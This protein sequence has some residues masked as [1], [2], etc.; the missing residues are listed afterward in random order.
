MKWA[1]AARS[2]AVA[3]IAVLFA[4][5]AVA[6]CSTGC[7]RYY[8]GDPSWGS[9]ATVPFTVSYGES[10]PY[11]LED[12]PWAQSFWRAACD[13]PG[14]V[15]T[16]EYTE[17]DTNGY[18]WIWDE[19]TWDSL[20]LWAYAPA[21]YDAGALTAVGVYPGTAVFREAQTYFNGWAQIAPGHVAGQWGRGEYSYST[22]DTKTWALHETG[23]WLGLQDLGS[24]IPGGTVWQDLYCYSCT[25]Y[26]EISLVWNGPAVA[27]GDGD[28]HGLCSLYGS[29]SAGDITSFAATP[30]DGRVR[31]EWTVSEGSGS[32]EFRIYASADGGPYVLIYEGEGESGELSFSTWDEEVVNG[33]QY[34][35]R[36]WCDDGIA[37]AAYCT[38]T[39][40]SP[41]AQVS[42]AACEETQAG[43]L[44][45]WT[46]TSESQG[47][48]GFDVYRSEDRDHIGDFTKLTSTPLPAHGHAAEYE[49][50][51]SLAA[52]G[53]PHSYLIKGVASA[54]VE[55]VGL[56]L[57]PCW[58]P[59]LPN[60][61]I[62]FVGT[63]GPCPVVCPAGD[64]SDEETAPISLEIVLR[65]SCGFPIEGYPPEDV[66][67]YAHSDD[68][69]YFGLCCAAEQTTIVSR[70]VAAATAATDSAGTTHVDI[71]WGGGADTLLQITAHLSD[72]RQMDGELTTQVHSPD[73]DSDCQVGIQDASLFVSFYGTTAWQADFNC[74]GHVGV[75]DAIVFQ[76]HY[77]HSCG[78]SRT[79]PVP[80]EFLAA[81]T[82][83]AVV[84]SGSSHFSLRPNTPNPFGPSTSISYTVP[85]GGSHVSVS[86]FNLTGRLVKTLVDEKASPGV[87]TLVWDGTDD[88]GSL[89]PGGVY[90]YKIDAP[91]FTEHRR[92]VLLR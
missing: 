32:H 51:D 42:Q 47:L 81:L 1:S 9:Y 27:P 57:N 45:S 87:H 48:D 83:T 74:D 14:P 69:G 50:A 82:D 79:E 12:I 37:S 28:R 43:M 17:Q 31:L 92:M 67:A 13:P 75:Q 41:L 71:W 58:K 35:Y 70:H 60:C 3:A 2:L 34:V 88:R 23:H 21:G 72:G 6:G 86:V 22:A 52:H 68:P 62:G 25:M 77:G 66:L 38:P 30:Y 65:D 7:K 8:S 33:T 84:A 46:T 10:V 29:T 53:W 4:Q 11:A 59:Y 54:D 5:A 20:G 61:E 40:A 15:P 36:M 18:T 56:A 16:F 19:A 90:F 39:G 89:V 80:P 63:Q 44:V 64:I 73:L 85:A 91:G 49:F 26:A 24:M 76:A 55:R 78:S